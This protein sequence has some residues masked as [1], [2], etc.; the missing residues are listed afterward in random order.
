MAH[1]LAAYVTLIIGWAYAEPRRMRPDPR[2]VLNAVRVLGSNPGSCVLVSDSLSDIEAAY[3]AGVV[4]IGDANRGWK[5]GA[6]T[7]PRSP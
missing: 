5:V 2:P 3:A 6:F 7:A 1:D 4:A